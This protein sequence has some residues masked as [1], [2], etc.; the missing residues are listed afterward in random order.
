MDRES[1][2]LEYKR[3]TRTQ[4]GRLRRTGRGPQ[5]RYVIGSDP[6]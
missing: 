4:A 1:M 3:D 6:E 5:P 2:S